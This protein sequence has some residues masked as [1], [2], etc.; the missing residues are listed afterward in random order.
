M[1]WYD[2][3]YVGGLRDRLVGPA[4]LA[5]AGGLVLLAVALALLVPKHRTTY[6]TAG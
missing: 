4:G 5:V 2:V 1:L 6:P 3:P